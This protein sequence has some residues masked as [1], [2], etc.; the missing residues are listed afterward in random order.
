MN[1]NTQV[2]R[3]VLFNSSFAITTSEQRCSCLV[4]AQQ[5]GVRYLRRR[6][7]GAKIQHF[8]NFELGLLV[9][10]I[11]R[12]T[13]P[14]NAMNYLQPQQPRLAMLVRHTAIGRLRALDTGGSVLTA[15]CYA[16]KR[17]K[18]K[19][20][21]APKTS[22]P[23]ATVTNT[24]TAGAKAGASSSIAAATP[25]RKPSTSGLGVPSASPAAS[26]AASPVSSSI[27]TSTTPAA[28]ATDD[29]S[30]LAAAREE[31]LRTARLRRIDREKE[32]A[33]QEEKERDYKERYD[34]AAK[35]YK[36]VVTALPILLVTSYFLFQQCECSSGS[37]RVNGV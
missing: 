3:L 23:R 12:H 5:L 27:P 28:A 7:T 19:A 20:A 37:A 21:T 11:A 25:L 2:T 26:P 13:Q 33:R 18:T 14:P 9:L 31:T 16:T 36:L 4:L 10:R 24:T 35:R 1:L 30:A 22:K 34:G 8:P 29:G 15:R 17:T 6:S 32:A